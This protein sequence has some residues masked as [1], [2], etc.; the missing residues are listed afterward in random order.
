MPF[1]IQYY[2]EVFE[3]L[4]ALS[5]DEFLEVDAY[6][7]KLKV[8]P[9]LVSLPLENLGDNLLSECRKIYIANATIR[10]VIRVKNNEIQIVELIAVGPR[11]GGIVYDEAYRRLVDS[12]IGL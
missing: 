11:A 5:D 3:D 9:F 2:P 4:E 1:K 12:G 8:N 6:I 10:M 7:E